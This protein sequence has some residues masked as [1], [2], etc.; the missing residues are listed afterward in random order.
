MRGAV[1]RHHRSSAHC[2]ST[3]ES[4]MPP[5]LH[6]HLP[7]KPRQATL[8]PMSNLFS[9]YT[10]R[11]LTLR[12]RT[13]VSPMCQYMARPRRRQRL[14]LRPSRPLRPRRLRPRHRR[15]HRRHARRPAS[16]TA[17]SAS[18]RTRRSPPSPA[19]SSSSTS[20]APPPASS[21]PTPAA[22]PRPPSAGAAA[23]TR[24]TSRRPSVGYETWVPVAPSAV[25]AHHKARQRLPDPHRAR[26]R[27]PR[28]RRA[29]LRRRHTPRRRR[30]LRPRRDPRRARL[31]AQP[32]PVA[33]RQQAHRRLRRHP[34]EPHAPPPRSRRRRPR[35]LAGGQAD[36][37]PH[38]DR[39]RQPRRLG[40]RGQPRLRRRAQGARRRHRRLLV[41]RL[42]GLRRQGRS[43]TTRSPSPPR[44]ASAGIATMAVGLISDRRDGRARSSPTAKP[45]SS[46]SPAAPSTIP[47][48]RSTPTTPSTAAAPPT[49]S[50]PSRPAPAC[51][52]R[53]RALGRYPVVGPHPT[54]ARRVE[55]SRDALTSP[56]QGE[57]GA[58]RR[59]RACQTPIHPQLSPAMALRPP[60]PGKRRA[61]FKHRTQS[62]FL[63]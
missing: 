4:V 24:P 57:V 13:V 52:D 18:G 27:R 59:V 45:T 2:T 39:R 63:L 14:A 49:T 9:P 61:R 36:L 58:K 35:R 29:E 17:I 55:R 26:R 40:A 28:P 11:G 44:S 51:R 62:R 5:A 33:H 46:P 31:P 50:G 15:G 56:S 23:S 37:G 19:S 12:N 21:S 53:D 42:R 32:V 38:L 41:R 8:A 60:V 7:M 16:P 30:R 47:T 6:R 22:R 48:G 25:A 3:N 34:R 10:L 43:R 20:T 54:A 1:S